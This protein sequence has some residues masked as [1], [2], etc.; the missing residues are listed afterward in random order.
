MVRSFVFYFTNRT[1]VLILKSMGHVLIA[2][3]TKKGL[4]TR[5]TILDEAIKIASRIG[6]EGLTIGTLADKVGMSK[7]GLFAHFKSKDALQLAVL[8]R[9]ADLFTTK[10]LA[11][12]FKS[13]RGQPR[14]QSIFENWIRFLNDELPGGSIFVAASFELDDRP[15][16]LRDYVHKAQRDLIRSLEKAAEL[17]IEEGHFS[18]NVDVGHF[19]WTLYSFV[20]GY[21]HS[22]RMIE[23]PN[24]ESHLRAAFK[25][26]LS[27]CSSKNMLSNKMRIKKRA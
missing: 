6:L 24:A 18:R 7:S 27:A 23:D 26:L 4:N 1:I 11:E 14:I 8:K 12:S 22:K 15:G 21:H 10:V 20:L 25:G 16:L 9:A 13:S 5:E 19:A 17:A 3:I 2:K